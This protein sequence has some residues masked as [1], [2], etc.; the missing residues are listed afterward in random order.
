MKVALADDSGIFRNSLARSLADIGAQVLIN[1]STGEELLALLPNTTV[2]VAIIDV[3]MP[4]TRTNEGL[5]TA[6]SIKSGYPAVSVL[7]LSA[8][9]ATPQAIELLR[10]FD[11]GIGYLQKDEVADIQE[12]DDALKRINAGEPV[13]GRDIVQRLLRTPARD[14]ALDVL[15]KQERQVLRLMAEGFSNAGI[16]RQLYLTERTVEDH[17]GRVFSKLE[18][19]GL[20]GTSTRADNNKRVLAVLTWL[21]LTNGPN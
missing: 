16:A 5:L 7:L 10:E 6:R 17:V 15:S 4:P 20:R 13:I 14:R 19:A 1:V 11:N 3:A 21:R 2:D 12:L 18:V 9:A 8:H